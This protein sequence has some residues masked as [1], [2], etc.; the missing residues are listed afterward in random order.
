MRLVAESL[1]PDM[2]SLDKYESYYGEGSKGELRVYMNRE[3]TQNEMSYVGDEIIRQGVCGSISQGA[4]ILFVSFEKRVAPLL[5]IAT[6]IGATISGILG[7]QL[8]KEVGVPAW[9]W[10]VGGC[11]LAYLIS[12]RMR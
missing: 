12:R 2:T 9:A 8:F 7:W 3:L 4:R 5:I 6:I 1:G 11:A 10:M